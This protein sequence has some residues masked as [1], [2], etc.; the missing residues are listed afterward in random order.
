MRKK[1]LILQLGCFGDCLM[2]TAL[3][4]QLKKDNPSSHITWGISYKYKQAIFNNP[5]I[6]EIWEIIHDSN[7]TMG[8]NLWKRTKKIAQE[9]QKEKFFD[10]I[11]Y[12]QV[13]PD[14]LGNFDG[15]TRSSTFNAYKKKI[16]VSVQP[17]IR[18]FPNEIENVHNFAKRNNLNRY[19]HV[20]LCEC[21]PSSQQSSLNLQIMT[22]IA[23][24]IAKENSDFIFIIS[25]HIKLEERF[26][27]NIIDAS[28]LS[29]RENAELSKYCTFFV[30]CSSGLTWLLTSDHAKKLPTVQFLKLGKN[31]A[32]VK[33]DHQYYN[34]STE[35]IIETTETDKRKMADIIFDS[36]IDFPRAKIKY[37]EKLKPSIYTLFCNIVEL[38]RLRNPIKGFRGIIHSSKKFTNRNKKNAIVFIPIF[39]LLIIPVRILVEINNRFKIGK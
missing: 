14:N 8:G 15:T 7:E 27:D 33:Y 9:K 24:M 21:A 31:F 36:I 6:D 29:Y 17:V 1:F 2:V 30:G 26:A 25:S 38:F 12:S 10:E 3:A 32:S 5:D 11:I 35:H 34:L 16:T 20:V 23:S 37:D 39:I 28:E 19:K 18:L 13:P 22:S 4:K